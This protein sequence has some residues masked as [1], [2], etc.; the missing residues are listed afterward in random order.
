MTHLGRRPAPQTLDDFARQFAEV[1]ALAGDVTIVGIGITAPGLVEGTICRWIPNLPYLDGVDLSHLA[2]PHAGLFA[3]GNDAHFAL[4][5][6]AT[7]GAASGIANAILLAI[8]TGIGSAVLADGLIVRG[9]HGG[10]A[11]FGWACADVNDAGHERLGWLERNASGRALDALGRD[12]PG[13]GDGAALIAN[14]RRGDAASRATIDTIAARIGTALAGA[15]ALLDPEVVLIAGGLAEAADILTP[16]L[17]T[18][19]KRQLPPHLRG[20]RLMPGKFGSQAGL[21]GAAVAATRGDDW[22]RAT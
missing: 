14:A 21:V 3:L 12:L 7:L 13:G 17:L 19:L 6:E 2:G 15:V 18:V 16:P 22:W 8:G 9:S 11:S 20:I 5:A 10:A 1:V 4:L